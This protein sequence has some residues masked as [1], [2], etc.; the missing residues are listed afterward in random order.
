MRAAGRTCD[1]RATARFP[2]VSEESRGSCRGQ[3]F[4]P[5]HELLR[6]RRLFRSLGNKSWR[7][8][9]I[10]QRKSSRQWRI[11]K[12]ERGCLRLGPLFIGDRHLAGSGWKNET[13][14]EEPRCRGETR[15]WE[16]KSQILHEGVKTFRVTRES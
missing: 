2:Y 5:E 4:P 14:A 9:D 3:R 13:S 7:G 6:P 1:V 12:E 11:R 10:S 8:R 15:L 16:G